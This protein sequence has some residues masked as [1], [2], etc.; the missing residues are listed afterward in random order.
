MIS[1]IS[2]LGASSIPIWPLPLSITSLIWLLLQ[3]RFF[4]QESPYP[5]HLQPKDRQLRIFENMISV[6]SVLMACKDLSHQFHLFYIRFPLYVQY[7]DHRNERK[8]FGI[9]PSMKAGIPSLLIFST[10]FKRP[11]FQSHHPGKR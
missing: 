11:P 6:H 5:F 8:S 2:L 1:S 4:Q 3:K 10:D 9:S 7:W